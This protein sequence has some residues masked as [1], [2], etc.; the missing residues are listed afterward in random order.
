MR[1]YR[2]ALGLDKKLF[3][4]AIRLLAK[5]KSIICVYMLKSINPKDE[6]KQ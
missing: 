6:Q 1:A 3:Q 2:F 5:L 4:I